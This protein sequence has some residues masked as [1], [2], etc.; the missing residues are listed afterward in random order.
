MYDVEFWVRTER[1]GE[2]ERIRGLSHTLSVRFILSLSSEEN[3]PTDSLEV[4]AHTVGVSLCGVLAPGVDIGVQGALGAT[5]GVAGVPSS[6]AASV[7]TA[8]S[9]QDF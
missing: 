8:P 9:P 3:P 7:L 1:R 6:A 5:A 4:G 2:R